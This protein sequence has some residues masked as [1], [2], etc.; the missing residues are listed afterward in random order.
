MQA[1]GGGGT[2]GRGRELPSRICRPLSP[3]PL[4]AFFVCLSPPPSGRFA[5]LLTADGLV[6][7]GPAS[8]QP[9]LAKP[10]PSRPPSAAASPA[11]TGRR[12][13]CSAAER[14][15]SRILGNPLRPLA[16]APSNDLGLQGAVPSNQV[17]ESPASPQ[18]CSQWNTTPATHPP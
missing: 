13:P 1:P 3:P 10:G 16:P 15:R 7:L 12:A 5:A 11:P 18:E 17:S 6:T 8:S 4:T 14:A 2:G 9:P